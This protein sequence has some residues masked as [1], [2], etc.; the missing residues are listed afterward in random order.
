LYQILIT[1]NKGKYLSIIQCNQ[2]IK[3]VKSADYYC[4]SILRNITNYLV[5]LWYNNII[6]AGDF[7]KDIHLESVKE[8][9]RINGLKDTH[10]MINSHSQYN[11]DFNQYFN[12]KTNIIDIA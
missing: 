8:F 9:F 1:T 2:I 7:N 10:S 3:V 4:R 12:Q 6:I 5:I 11:I